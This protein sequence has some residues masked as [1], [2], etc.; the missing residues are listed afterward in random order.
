MN[1]TPYRQ[2]AERATTWGIVP[3]TTAAWMILAARKRGWE[4][5]AV[6]P[7]DSSL[8]QKLTFEKWVSR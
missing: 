6:G 7:V 4:L 3:V 5:C 8:R 1:A 2:G